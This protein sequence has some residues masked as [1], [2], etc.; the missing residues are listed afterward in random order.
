MGLY[1]SAYKYRHIKPY[2]F[3]FYRF[4]LPMWVVIPW[5]DFPVSCSEH[6]TKPMAHQHSIATAFTSMQ[7]KFVLPISWIVRR[8]LPRI[9]EDF[10]VMRLIL[11]GRWGLHQAPAVMTTLSVDLSVQSI[12]ALNTLKLLCFKG[13]DVQGSHQMVISVISAFVKDTT[14]RIAQRCV[15]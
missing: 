13:K 14:L 1:S 10:R 9:S 8:P 3:L 4:Q 7:A 5:W 6:S 12:L 2:N 15:G 11:F